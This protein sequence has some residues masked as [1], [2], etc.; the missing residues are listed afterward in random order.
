[1]V[2]NDSDSKDVANIHAGP[3]GNQAFYGGAGEIGRYCINA[4]GPDTSVYVHNGFCRSNA[5]NLHPTQWFRN[6]TKVTDVR[7]VSP[8]GTILTPF[9]TAAPFYIGPGRDNSGGGGGSD[10]DGDGDE[11]GNADGSV[12]LAAA[13]APVPGRVY[14]VRGANILLS[15]LTGG[16]QGATL[17]DPNGDLFHADAT[18]LLNVPV[19]W[20]VRFASSDPVHVGGD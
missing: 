3:T 20:K 2:Y 12:S 15:I 16:Q 13:A 1:M 4:D 18:G 9:S 10:G 8:A 17:L 14:T 5:T 11:S 19:G 7:G 6:V